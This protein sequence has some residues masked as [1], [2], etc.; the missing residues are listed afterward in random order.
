[1]TELWL[2]GAGAL[3][4]HVKYSDGDEEDL[5]VG[6]QAQGQGGQARAKRGAACERRV[7]WC[8]VQA[9]EVVGFVT[10]LAKRE[11]M[12]RMLEA[13]VKRKKASSSTAGGHAG[14]SPCLRVSCDDVGGCG[15]VVQEAE[16]CVL[17]E[18]ELS[19]LEPDTPLYRLQR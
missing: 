15:W 4:A 16:E 19:L 6:R 9:H 13:R 12:R 18:L 3:R 10:S 1:M 5:E 8:V 14:L 2:N 11:Q 7:G 17:W